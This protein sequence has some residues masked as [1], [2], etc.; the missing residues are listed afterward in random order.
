MTATHRPSPEIDLSDAQSHLRLDHDLVRAMA[1]RALELEGIRGGS[2]SIAVVDDRAILEVNRAH[3]DHDWPTDVISFLFSE[4]GDPGD[5]SGEV[6]I[7][8]EMA[9]SVASRCGLDPISEFALYLVHGVL[10]LCGYDD[11]TDEGRARMRER[12]DEVL[13]ALGISPPPRGD[14]QEAGTAPS[15]WEGGL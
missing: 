4:P 15:G 9:A 7:S 12:E 6:V 1:R 14:D 10:H 3:L 11:L 5:F 13:S 2:L 8:A